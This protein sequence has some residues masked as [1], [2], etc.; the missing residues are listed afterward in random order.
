[1][2]AN[3]TVTGFDYRK[4]FKLVC[5]A[6][7]V[8]KIICYKLWLAD[9]LFPLVPI[10]ESLATIPPFLHSALFVISLACLLAFLFF[11]D[12]KIMILL[13]LAELLSCMLDQNRWQPWEYQFIFMLAA[14]VFCKE[15][16]Q[17]LFAWQW[18]IAGLYFFGGL[19]KLNSAFIHDT[20][21][22]LVLHKWLGVA[23]TNISI[24]R[25]GYLLPLIEMAAGAGLLFRLSRKFSIVILISTHLIIL[26]MFGPFGLNRSKGIWPWNLLMPVCLYYLF[27]NKAVVF[28]R[29]YL[30]KPFNRL[31]ILCWCI[32]PWLQLVG[33]WDKNLSA[34]LYS[35][36]VEQLFICTKNPAAQ[37][38]MA[39]YYT[40][41]TFRFIPCNHSLSVFEW[42]LKEIHT[43]PYP[44]KRVFDAIILAWK[45]R[46]PGTGDRFYLYKPGFSYSVKEI[47]SP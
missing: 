35:G 26:L 25:A 36:G 47:I 1:M 24:T 5:I 33:Y 4:V 7:F 43:A 10:H 40:D 16:K 9:R 15:E 31:V 19:G 18:I 20:W 21:Q 34:V 3:K 30:R 8:S 28:N 37:K 46:Y 27:Y 14:M 22:Y 44:E 11:P 38:Q 17:V 39:P 41:S 6:W 13:L 23:G 42:S 45:K 12:K 2:S 29:S 32:L